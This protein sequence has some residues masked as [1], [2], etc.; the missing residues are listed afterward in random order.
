MSGLFLPIWVLVL[1]VDLV[2][3]LH[4][5]HAVFKIFHHLIQLHL[6]F[7]DSLAYLA[8]ECCDT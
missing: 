4:L 2:L 1:G 6:C 5:S 8:S 3:A 7:R